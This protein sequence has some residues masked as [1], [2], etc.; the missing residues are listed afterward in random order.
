[1]RSDTTRGA[2]GKVNDA[3]IK[4]QTAQIKLKMLG[5]TKGLLEGGQQQDDEAS[6]NNQNL[7]QSHNSTRTHQHTARPNELG[8]GQGGL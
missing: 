1:M 8:S 7:K 2:H 4:P 6:C 5:Q 3:R